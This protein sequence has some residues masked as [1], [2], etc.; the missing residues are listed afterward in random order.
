M[1]SLSVL[2]DPS[3]AIIF[4][5]SPTGL[6]HLRVTEALYR[7]LPP[8][9][10]PVLL[11]AQDQLA[12]TLYRFVSIHPLTR[13]AMTVMQ[14]PP[15]DKPFAVV[16]R[17]LL[18]SQTKILY[19]QLKT[20]LSERMIVPKTVLLVAPHTILGHQLGA[21][22]EQ[23]AKEMGV[24]ILLVVQVTDDSPQA[25][26]YVYDAD[27]MLVPSQYTK[28]KLESYAKRA[29]LPHVPMVVT[30]YPISPKFAEH[31]S[32]SQF[33]QRLKQ[34]D[35]ALRGTIHMTVPVSGAAVQTSFLS[36]Y[37]TSLHTLSERFQ[38]HVVSREAPYTK[39][40][41]AQMAQ[42]P[43]VKLHT[44]DHDRTTVLNYENVFDEFPVALEITKPSEQSF[45]ALATPKQLGG[46]ILLFSAPVGG[47]EFDNLHFLRNH[48]MLPSKDNTKHLWEMAYKG[49]SIHGAD[50]VKDAH[51]WR[52]LRLP[53]EPQMAASF[54]KWCLQEGLF[55][56]M[57]HYTRALH[58]TEVQSN[59]VE[60]FWNQVAELVEKKTA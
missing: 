51:H 57:M 7:G 48:G 29:H 46:P 14:L 58:T 19:G 40:F 9:A 18:R 23:M 2:T 28:E 53:D 11:G 42:Y 43:Y 41:V 8:N 55:M 5:T 45:K 33:T 10:S 26:W 35:R 32:E 34:V 30:A 24:Q 16:G 47:Q 54:T 3:L 25:I 52:A 6:G 21:I 39:H 49:E 13:Q 22:K 12:S 20:I 1:A 31:I 38:F 4:A 44:S 36:D 60:Q 59:G 37:I 50:L 56:R 27:L 15:I 17:K